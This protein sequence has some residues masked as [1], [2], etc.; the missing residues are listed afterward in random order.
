ML[1][2]KNKIQLIL[3]W[4][5]IKFS[6]YSENIYANNISLGQC[7]GVEPGLRKWKCTKV[8]TH[9]APGQVNIFTWF[10]SVVF[11]SLWNF[12]DFMEVTRSSSINFPKIIISPFLKLCW[13][14]GFEFCGDLSLAW[15]KLTIHFLLHWH[16]AN[17]WWCDNF[18]RYFNIHHV[19]RQTNDKFQRYCFYCLINCV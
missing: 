18:W 8:H 12:V 10:V 5:Q 16:N 19:T 15:G 2:G 11:Q 6:E 17:K 4:V 9:I 13:V 14:Y 7:Q 3:T 1:G